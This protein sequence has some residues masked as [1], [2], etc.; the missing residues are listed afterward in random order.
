MQWC[1]VDVG[2]RIG[3][4]KLNPDRAGEPLLQA[5]KGCK[6]IVLQAR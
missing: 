2:E 6:I 3:L 5:G 1:L 4:G